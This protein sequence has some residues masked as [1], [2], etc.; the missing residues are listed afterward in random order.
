MNSSVNF[1][2]IRN[3]RNQNALMTYHESYVIFAIYV[4]D[5]Y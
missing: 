2:N 4:I 5:I 1:H 3:N